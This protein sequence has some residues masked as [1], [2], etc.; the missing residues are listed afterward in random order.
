M[1]H[2]SFHAWIF[3][4]RQ[5]VLCW[6]MFSIDSE[7]V[8]RSFMRACY[9]GLSFVGCSQMHALNCMYWI[10]C[11]K[12]NMVTF[13]ATSLCILCVMN[14]HN[15]LPCPFLVLPPL[16][17][18]PKKG[19]KTQP[20]K[21]HWSNNPCNKSSLKPCN[22]HSVFNVWWIMDNGHGVS[23]LWAYSDSDA[24]YGKNPQ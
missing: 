24:R 21:H 7:T 5:M 10:T 4:S 6:P 13:H 20:W 15:C 19:R 22:L 2:V 18:T 12:S 14:N 11:T 9:Q 17:T 3:F 1:S 8:A 23:L 16:Y